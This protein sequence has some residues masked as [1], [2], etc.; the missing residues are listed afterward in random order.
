ML[1][2]ATEVLAGDWDRLIRPEAVAQRAVRAAIA[3]AGHAA[4]LD[5]PGLDLEVSVLFADDAELQRL[6]RDY[7]GQDRP[8]NILAFPMLGPADAAR[9]LGEGEGCHLLGDLALAFETVAAEAAAQG[10]LFAH[11]LTHLLV[12]GT[13]HLLGH[14]HEAAAEAEAMERLE[15]RILSA[16]G[17]PDPYVCGAA[18]DG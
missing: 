17:I 14:V 7:R 10:R 12:H 8:T 16:L 13:L 2:V 4:A 5:R 11:H 1:E 6:N 9:L 15:A 18:A 3:G